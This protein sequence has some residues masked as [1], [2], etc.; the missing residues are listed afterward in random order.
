MNSPRWIESHWL[1]IKVVLFSFFTLIFLILLVMLIGVVSRVE[2]SAQIVLYIFLGVLVVVVT[3]ALAFF[4][5]SSRSSMRWEAEVK[6]LKQEVHELQIKKSEYAK[7][8]KD[9]THLHHDLE[10]LNKH[11]D[12][13]R[14]ELKKLRTEEKHEHG[15]D[16][17][18]EGKGR[19]D[20]LIAKVRVMSG[21][22][23]KK[24]G[25]HG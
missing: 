19:L 16:L 14:K 24:K 3:H 11:Y 2:G 6:Q 15:E 1:K 13:L 5:G 17:W 20:A 10:H 25:D 8:E 18:R 12:H 4:Y 7:N 23:L 9:L 21:Q 22:I